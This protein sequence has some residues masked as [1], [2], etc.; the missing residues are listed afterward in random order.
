MCVHSKSSTRYQ[1]DCATT[2]GRTLEWGPKVREARRKATTEMQYRYD[3]ATTQGTERTLEWG[4]QSEGGEKESNIRCSTDALAPR[5][6]EASRRGLFQGQGERCAR[7]PETN[8]TAAGRARGQA[9]GHGRVAASLLGTNRAC[10]AVG[11]PGAVVPSHQQPVVHCLVG[12]DGRHAVP[13][14]AHLPAVDGYRRVVQRAADG[15]HARRGAAEVRLRER[16]DH[17]VGVGAI[18]VSWVVC[19]RGSCERGGPLLALAL[20][21]RH[22]QNCKST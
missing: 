15:R 16:A 5:V 21:Q 19:E 1:F 14:V 12:A 20:H 10:H 9:R 4:T 18:V 13:A 2:Q 7:E 22:Q 6:E 11:S 8:P 17:G 3:C